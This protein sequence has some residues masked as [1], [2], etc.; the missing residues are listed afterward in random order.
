MSDPG[1]DLTPQ[2]REFFENYL[3][4]GG[5]L[6]VGTQAA[7]EAGY[8]KQTAHVQASR[9]LRHVKGGQYLEFLKEK[10]RKQAA[11]EGRRTP[12]QD[13]AD[14]QAVSIKTA[15]DR[16]RFYS[17]VIE[18]GETE[19]DKGLQPDGE[20]DMAVVRTGLAAA[21]RMDEIDRINSGGE[22]Q[23]K[24]LFEI[25]EKLKNLGSGG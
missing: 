2:Q 22:D 15:A 16:L 23:I 18:A 10:A 7:I 21:K 5:N 4:L 3:R 25:G 12:E 13:A 24:R 11:R 19:L 9:L 17:K 6:G 1:E 14:R 8:S 20:A